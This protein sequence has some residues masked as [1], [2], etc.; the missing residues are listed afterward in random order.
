MFPKAL[1]HSGYAIPDG[2]SF[3]SAWRGTG[4]LPLGR[5]ML[6]SCGN[7]LDKGHSC[8]CSLLWPVPCAVLVDE[9]SHSL[10]P[11]I[12]NGIVPL[13]PREQVV[14]GVFNSRVKQG[15][16]LLLQPLLANPRGCSSPLQNSSL[17]TPGFGIHIPA[18][19]ILDVPDN[20]LLLGWAF[21]GFVGFFFFSKLLPSSPEMT[22]WPQSAC[23]IQPLSTLFSS[24]A[25]FYG[26][27]L[28]QHKE[29]LLN[30]HHPAGII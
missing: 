3:I 29:N 12:P 17:Q 8:C 7:P 10:H 24:F 23:K 11:G 6:L 13:L 20:E 5:G 21:L 2:E 14:V 22:P 19:E 9:L 30:I 4:A 25:S 1:L 15:F 27:I 16:D 26:Q 18:L 28:Y